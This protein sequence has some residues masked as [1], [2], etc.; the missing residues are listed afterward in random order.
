MHRSQQYKTSPSTVIGMVSLFS[1][2]SRMVVAGLDGA[3]LALQVAVVWLV[4]N[5]GMFRV[6]VTEL[7]AVEVPVMGVSQVTLTTMG[8]STAVLTVT[9]H[10][11]LA[12]VPAIRTE[13][14]GVTDTIGA[15]TVDRK[16]I[17][18]VS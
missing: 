3:T 11:R 12:D 10:S 18:T 17:I 1:E 5:T 6:S 4:L 16:L 15:G 14:G 2:L 13:M 8:M 9:T 7:V